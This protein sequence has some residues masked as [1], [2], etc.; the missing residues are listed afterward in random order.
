MAYLC[1]P[2]A[3]P[4]TGTAKHKVAYWSMLGSMWHA[5]RMVLRVVIGTSWDF[6]ELV[7]MLLSEASLFR[8]IQ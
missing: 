3:M 1:W 6:Q 4:C 8:R 5:V 7:P 2:L